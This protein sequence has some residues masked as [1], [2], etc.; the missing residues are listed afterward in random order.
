VTVKMSHNTYI[1]CEQKRVWPY[2]TVRHISLRWSYINPSGVL[3]Q[4]KRLINNGGET[5]LRHHLPEARVALTY[6]HVL[7]V[8]A[9]GTESVLIRRP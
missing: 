6:F 7:L 2:F 5:E 4:M 3:Q 8:G 1:N 9:L